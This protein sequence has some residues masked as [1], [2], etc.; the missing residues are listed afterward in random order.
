MEQ[1]SRRRP[2][3]LSDRDRSV[4]ELERQWGAGPEHQSRKLAEAAEQLGLDRTGYA[5]VLRA[6]LDD[7]AAYAHD[8]QTVDALR[9]VR[10]AR[11]GGGDRFDSAHVGRPSYS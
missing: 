5:L 9:G 1:V 6:L 11:S 4:L 2:R 8:P 3:P 10:D 7:P